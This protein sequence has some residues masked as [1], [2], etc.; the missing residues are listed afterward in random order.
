MINNTLL[1]SNAVATKEEGKEKNV[2]CGHQGMEKGV[3][4]EKSRL[5]LTAS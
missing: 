2:L 1:L 3:E 5:P 4:M